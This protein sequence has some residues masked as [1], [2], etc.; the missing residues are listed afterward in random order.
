[1]A[2]EYVTSD[3]LKATLDLSGETFA[4]A[5]IADALETASRVID[6]TCKRR[7]YADANV[8]QVR[9][10]TPVVTNLLRIDDL[11]TLTSLKTDPGGDGTFEETWVE[12][13]DFVLCPLNPEL[14]DAS[15]R[16]PWTL[17][18]THPR[19]SYE[20]PTR[21]PR[22]VQVTGK[23]G[24][25]AVPSQVSTATTLLAHRFLR[26]M[27]E[28][29]F[30]I[31]GIGIDQLAARLPTTDPDVALMLKGLVRSKPVF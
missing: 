9:Y 27:R 17:I 4:N 10:Y 31:I 29:P 21:Y 16:E 3:E 8:N 26:R 1:M 5:D 2:N 18:E 23:F 12:N 25:A 11:V 19:G 22:S 13:T 28:A 24:W 20:F 15:V 6:K 30:A 7:F 14:V